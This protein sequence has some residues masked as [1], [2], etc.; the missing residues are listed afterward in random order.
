MFAFSST[1]EFGGK[2]SFGVCVLTEPMTLMA[3]VRFKSIIG[4]A[5]PLV[6][7]RRAPPRRRSRCPRPD[8]WTSLWNSLRSQPAFHKRRMMGKGI[9]NVGAY[10][11]TSMR[12]KAR[13]QFLRPVLKYK[14]LCLQI[15]SSN[16]V[17]A[18]HL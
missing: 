7:G 16:P 15:L 14:G 8:S 17:K 9:Q 18:I 6:F 2:N 10:A 13:G 1:G 4:E 3:C 12:R 5:G 11:Q